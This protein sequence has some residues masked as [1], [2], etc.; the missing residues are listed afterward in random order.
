M[1]VRHD[2]AALLLSSTFLRKWRDRLDD[3]EVEVDWRAHLHPAA[4]PVI[5]ISAGNSSRENGLTAVPTADLQLTEPPARR[6][7]TDAQTEAIAVETAQP[8]PPSQA[9]PAGTGLSPGSCSAGV[10]S[11]ALRR[12]CAQSLRPSYWRTAWRWQMFCAI[13]C[14][15][16][17]IRQQLRW[18][19]S[20]TRPPP[21]TA[22][23]TLFGRMPHVTRPRPDVHL[24]WCESASGFGLHRH[25]QGPRWAITAQSP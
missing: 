19:T 8:E 22:V 9:L 15:R 18:R 7:F 6:Y 16:P 4:R 5:G 21:A 23:L 25:A 24:V 10:Y 1:S 14:D 13:L 11:S 3:G 12:R 20:C 17:T 2:A